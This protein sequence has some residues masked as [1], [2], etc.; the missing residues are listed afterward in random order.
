MRK[1]NNIFFAPGVHTGGGLALLKE[2]EPFLVEGNFFCI[3]DLRLKPHVSDELIRNSS[4]YAPGIIG[5]VMAELALVRFS[6]Y[7]TIVICF[8]S[9]APIMS[10]RGVFNV[11]FQNANLLCSAI[12]NEGRSSI[13]PFVNSLLVRLGKKKINKVIVQ[14]PTMKRLYEDKLG[15]SG[16]IS[17]IP[18]S[19]EVV[20]SYRNRSGNKNKFLYVADASEHKNHQTLLEAWIL[21]SDIGIYPELTVTLSCNS[22]WVI[23]SQAIS[24]FKLKIINAGY[25]GDEKLSSLYTESSALIYPSLNESFGLP[26][27]EA[28]QY[29]LP[30]IA[31][32]LD[33]VRDVCKPIETFNPRSPVSIKRAILRYTGNSD[34]EFISI[35]T[36]KEFFDEI[37][38]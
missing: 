29:L 36:S 22:L 14:T 5:R 26:L 18:F 37:K 28:S 4:F 12:K 34:A 19:K 20:Y 32:E 8:H 27:I 6:T 7:R 31:S 16:E 10:N 11:F 33:F 38:Q 1:R 2:I 25:C 24:K 30:I 35:K 9:M 15:F 3:L 17:V 23:Y 21:L 13:K